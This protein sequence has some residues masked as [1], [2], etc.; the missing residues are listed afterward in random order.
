MG[1]QA[2][3]ECSSLGASGSCGRRTG[4]RCERVSPAPFDA[5]ASPLSR[6]LV[7]MTASL[8]SD[9]TRSVIG[10]AALPDDALIPLLASRNLNDYLHIRELGRG[11]VRISESINDYEVGRY[12]A[13]LEEIAEGG[14]P[15]A[16][17]HLTS[18]G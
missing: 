13:L 2:P 9:R 11:V 18:S 15:E 10:S 4:P 1:A 16:R 12:L 14:L 6:G 5:L 3:F 8:E 7:R 17:L